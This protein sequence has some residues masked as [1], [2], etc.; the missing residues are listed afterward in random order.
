MAD[1][2]KDGLLMESSKANWEASKESARVPEFGST[3]VPLPQESRTDVT[4]VAA[5]IFKE[6][7][8]LMTAI[9]IEKALNQRR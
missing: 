6:N 4:L 3:A 8:R 1:A 2:M 5:R 7:L 9:L